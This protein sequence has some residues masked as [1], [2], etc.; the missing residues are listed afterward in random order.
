MTT[1]HDMLIE[2]VTDQ[3]NSIQQMLSDGDYQD[4]H[5]WL[6]PILLR[7][8]KLDCADFSDD[9]LKRYYGDRL[10]IDFPSGPT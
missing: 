6:H 1:R 5:N 7:E 3:I 8:L 10:G 4:V 9:D 2:L